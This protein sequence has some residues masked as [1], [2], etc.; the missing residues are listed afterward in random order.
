MELLFSLPEGL[1]HP[2]Q[3]LAYNPGAIWFCLN[4]EFHAKIAK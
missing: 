4:P 3:Q 2:L 1:F